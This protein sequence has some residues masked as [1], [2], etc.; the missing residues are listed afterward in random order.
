MTEYAKTDPSEVMAQIESA[1]VVT[2]PWDSEDIQAIASEIKT[3]LL[4]LDP[5]Q[6]VHVTSNLYVERLPSHL[7]QEIVAAVRE[8]DAAFVRTVQEATALAVTEFVQ[9][10][11]DQRI[12]DKVITV[13]IGAGLNHAVYVGVEVGGDNLAKI[14]PAELERPGEMVAEWMAKHHSIELARIIRGRVTIQTADEVTA[15]HF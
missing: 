8:H 11:H 10:G 14:H 12:D 15:T 2:A 13:G 6:E 3:G 5:N 9:E 4:D 7:T 1:T